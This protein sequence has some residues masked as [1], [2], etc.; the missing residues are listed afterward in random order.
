MLTTRE[1]SERVKTQFASEG[2]GITAA[3]RIGDEIEWYFLDTELPFKCAIESGTG[4]AFDD[5]VPHETYP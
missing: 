5:R 4:H 1:E 3:G 2:I